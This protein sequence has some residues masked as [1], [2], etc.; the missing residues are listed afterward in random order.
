MLSSRK[1]LP[2]NRRK[3]RRRSACPLAVPDRDK[4]LPECL[5]MPIM[6]ILE[7]VT[8]RFYSAKSK[9]GEIQQIVDQ[10]K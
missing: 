9:F 10:G 3:V 1:E 7:S 5:M 2:P 6:L 8:Y 4:C